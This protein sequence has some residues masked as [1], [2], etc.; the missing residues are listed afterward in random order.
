LKG[1]SE[2]EYYKD[3]G[4]VKYTIG[5]SADYNE[6]LALRRSLLSDFPQAFIVAFKNGV[7]M[8]VNAAIAE[9]RKNK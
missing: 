8:D 3:G 9:F 1:H 4:N 5:S 6:I 2:A 7:R